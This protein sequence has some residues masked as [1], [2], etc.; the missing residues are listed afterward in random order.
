MFPIRTILFPTDF[1]DPCVAWADQVCTVAQHFGAEVVLL[2]VIQIPPYSQPPVEPYA[3]IVD[4]EALRCSSD[5]ELKSFAEENMLGA[6][7]RRLLEE[8]DAAMRIAEIA[9]QESADVVMMPSHGRG[10]F[11]HL[12]LGSTTAKA[13][14]DCDC[15]VWTGAHV[16]EFATRRSFRSIICAVDLRTDMSSA[17]AWAAAFRASYDAELTLVHAVPWYEDGGERFVTHRSAIDRAAKSVEELREKLGIE[18]HVCVHPG[19]IAEVMREA[20]LRHRA[21]LVVIGQGCMRKFMG[22]LRTN[23]YSIVRE[24]PCPVIRV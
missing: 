16:P 22:R 12:L 21:D 8:G 23:A 19:N 7:A 17:L 14:H 6:D 3:P 11:R 10:W 4:L 2:H 15:P 18:G 20:A 5:E 24:S 13:L 1:S 9:R